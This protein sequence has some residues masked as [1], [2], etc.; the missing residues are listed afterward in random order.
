MNLLSKYLDRHEFTSYE[1]FTQN[2][3]LNVPE[4]FNFGYDVVD[5][6]ARLQPDKMALVWCD[7]FGNDKKFTFQDLSTLSNK[8]ANFLISAGIKKGDTIMMILNRRYEYW[9]L[10]VACNKIGAIFIP[11]S[12]LLTEK[13]IEYRCDKANV[14]MV[15]CNNQKPIQDLL[16]KAKAKCPSVESYCTLSDVDGF[17]NLTTEVE[18]QS[19]VISID[20]VKNSFDP[21]MIYFTS[22]TTG[23]PKMVMHIQSYPLGHIVTQGF[24]H[25]IRDED[26][27]FTLADTGW[28]KCSWGKIYGAWISGAC[29]FVYDFYGK[30]TP[31]DL[32]PLIEKYKVTS[33]CA[34]PTVYRFLIKEDLSQYNLSSLTHMTSAGEPLN[35]EIYNQ[36][37]SKLGLKIREG[38][39]QTETCVMLATFPWCENKCGAMGLPS[40]LYDIHLI[41]EN[42]N[43]VP[44]GEEGEIC[45]KMPTDGHQHGLLKEYF[46]DEVANAN[47]FENGFYHTGDLAYADED[48][49]YWFVG[50]RDDIIKSSG[51]RIGPFE[52][53]SA[54][55]THPSVMECS[56]TAV[57]DELRGQIVKATVVLANGFTASEELKKELQNHV[58]STTAP[59]KYPRIVEFV[60]E[61]PKTISG[62]I[63]RVE[64]RAKDAEKK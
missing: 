37:L 31:L 61:L 11:A 42:Y 64:I 1:D 46:K 62:K 13:D 57:P 41:D 23:M 50:R 52:V 20:F 54:L 63:R 3:K 7:E 27:H 38:F 24:W 45:I 26:L 35:G 44:M 39:G 17:I 40:P 19:E 30:F 9:Y 32:L 58:K 55:L 25:F 5:E 14:K 2:F 53:E 18:K 56:I 16:T 6:Y 43:E 4:D 8:A 36:I 29:Q 47:A 51:Y 34:P 48:G 22:G 33:F 59:Y 15:I 12:H 28:A 49:Y 60:T 21:F 10:S